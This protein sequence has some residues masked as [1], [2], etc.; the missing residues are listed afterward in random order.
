MK[1]YHYS[2]KM[3]SDIFCLIHNYYLWNAL[4]FLRPWTRPRGGSQETERQQSPRGA[5]ARSPLVV[6]HPFSSLSPA[7][8]YPTCLCTFIKN[9]FCKNI[10]LTCSRSRAVK[11]ARAVRPNTLLSHGCHLALC[12]SA[13][14]CTFSF[15]FLPISVCPYPQQR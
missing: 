13:S 7:P 4:S 15:S 2:F 11:S 5:P 12:I 9:E 3:P 10:S 1:I 6:P 8:L 14:W